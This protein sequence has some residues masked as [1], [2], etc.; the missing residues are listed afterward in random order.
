MGDLIV[1][2]WS[3]PITSPSLQIVLIS[4]KMPFPSRSYMTRRE[5][6]L[7]R[8][9]SRVVHAI[10]TQMACRLC[11]T[12]WLAG[13]RLQDARSRAV[14]RAS[15]R[16]TPLARFLLS[17]FA[18]CFLFWPSPHSHYSSQFLESGRAFE[19]SFPNSPSP[20][21]CSSCFLISRI[22]NHLRIECGKRQ[23]RGSLAAALCLFA[24]VFSTEHF[25]LLLFKTR[26]CLYQHV[27][28]RGVSKNVKTKR[29]AGPD[30]RVGRHSRC[31]VAHSPNNVG[32]LCNGR[33]FRSFTLAIRIRMSLVVG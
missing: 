30:A 7:L 12:M 31:F 5:S 22:A 11:T 16:A 8:P 27:R 17:S 15:R 10:R 6:R 32:R 4:T 14:K 3:P 9:P 33:E 23:R 13:S 26:N 19:T 20:P 29:V 2:S 24:F 28:G 1:G 21:L 18:V 25:L